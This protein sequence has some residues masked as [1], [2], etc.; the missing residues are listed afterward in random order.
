MNVENSKARD[1]NALLRQQMDRER[2]DAFDEREV[3][4]KRM[5]ELQNRLRSSSSRGAPSDGVGSG[6]AASGA[7][8]FAAALG[9]SAAFPL[10]SPGAL[11]ESGVDVREQLRRVMQMQA[12]SER[13]LK[14]LRDQV[15][16]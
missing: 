10:S 8:P 4:N 15:S 16:S 6:G 9:A 11:S 12:A 1:E 14:T 13:E 2:Q 3:V 5:N 7:L